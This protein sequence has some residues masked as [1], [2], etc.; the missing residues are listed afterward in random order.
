MTHLKIF[1]LFVLVHFNLLLPAQEKGAE[2]NW[3]IPNIAFEERHDT[4]SWNKKFLSVDLK[5]FGEG[6]SESDSYRIEDDFPIQVL[7]FPVVDY[8]HGASGAGEFFIEG[9]YPISVSYFLIGKHGYNKHEFQDGVSHY[10]FFNLVVLTDT[11]DPKDY[12]LVDN[13]VTSRNHPDYVGQ[14]RIKTKKVKIDYV[15]FHRPDHTAY[16]IVGTKLFNLSDGQ[17][18]IAVVKEDSS[19]HFMQLKT[20]QLPHARVEPYI[21]RLVKNQPVVDFFEKSLA[22]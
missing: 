10:S 17:T 18:I 16:A 6:A 11:L 4:A 14:G 3:D 8:K 15:C 7:P 2:T 21:N 19:V 1:A 22:Y 5:Y 13:Y 9:K 12:S 20:P